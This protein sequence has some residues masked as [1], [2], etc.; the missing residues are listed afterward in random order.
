MIRVLFRYADDAD[1][2]IVG[3]FPPDQID[4]LEALLSATEVYDGESGEPERPRRIE[5]QWILAEPPA[6]PRWCLEFVWF[7]ISNDA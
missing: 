3:E 4:G 1:P 7:G 2:R 6:T 5:R